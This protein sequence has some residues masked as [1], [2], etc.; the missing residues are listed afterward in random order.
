MSAAYLDAPAATEVILSAVEAGEIVVVLILMPP[1]TDAG[2]RIIIRRAPDRVLTRMGTTGDDTI[3]SALADLAQNAMEGADFAQEGVHSLGTEA[4]LE[5]RFFLEV[6]R[7]QPELLIVGAGHIAQPLCSVGALLGF[8][9]R[10]LDDRP[11]F[12]TSERF[13]EA[14]EVVRIDMDDP[15]GR[16]PLTPE[17][18][19]VLVTRG[20]KYDY[21]CL[22][23]LLS[24][25]EEVRYIGMIGSRRRVRAAF[26]E[27]VEEGFDRERIAKIR[28]PVGLDLRA[29]TP[30][31]IAVAVAA[32]IVL[33]WRGGSAQPLADQERILPRFFEAGEGVNASGTD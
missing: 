14:E 24:R 12:A 33:L 3:D 2:G 26:T 21:A 9:V 30:A 7:P 31:E 18:H 27:L 25:E 20:H 10:V 4:G 15:F 11:A 13:P 23:Q 32:E 8:R 16:V 1:S 6:H 29:E 22:R 5:V 17:T 19:I 28:A